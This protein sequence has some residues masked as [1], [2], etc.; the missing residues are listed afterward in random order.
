MM[1]ALTLTLAMNVAPELHVNVKS[2]DV[3]GSDS[4]ISSDSVTMNLSGDMDIRGTSANTDPTKATVLNL[5]G[6][7]DTTQTTHT[8]KSDTLGLVQSQSGSGS[9]TQTLNL[10][11]INGDVTF[12]PTLTADVKLPEARNGR[13]LTARTAS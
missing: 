3:N 9:T 2:I 5:N 4:P 7:V 10:T 1:L 6:S 11:K 8:S 12:D 13:G